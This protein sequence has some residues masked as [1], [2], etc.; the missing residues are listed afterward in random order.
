MIEK[1]MKSRHVQKHATE[2]EWLKAN[3]FIPK[4]AEI[5]VYDVDEN[6]PYERFKIGDGVT[7]LKDLPFSNE[8]NGVKD[9]YTKGEVDTFLEQKQNKLYFYHED[10]IP[11]I[12]SQE[13]GS[14]KF[15][16]GPNGLSTRYKSSSSG[17]IQFYSEEGSN[18]IDTNIAN[19]TITFR[20]GIP[21]G[22]GGYTDEYTKTFAFVED[23]D[24]KLGDIDSVLDAILA[25]QNAV[26]GGNS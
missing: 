1:N 24:E 20:H 19:G 12:F 26:L 17:F 18:W 25:K 8:N 10:I 22:T 11:Q 14:T 2:S 4:Q 5:I 3:I 9:A 6:H 15:I 16:F 21:D 13:D 23:I 7:L